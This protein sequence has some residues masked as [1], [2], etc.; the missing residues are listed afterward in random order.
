MPT[1]PRS[2]Y[3]TAYASDSAL[4]AG[5]SWYRAFRQDVIDNRPP[6]RQRHI[7]APLLY[8]RGEREGGDIKAYVAGFRDAG[9]TLV[10]QCV[11][12][13]RATSRPRSSPPRPGG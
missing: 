6:G 9:L 5:F 10:S 4:T 1:A 8:L 12:P 3:V 11:L 13:A 2:P 7:T